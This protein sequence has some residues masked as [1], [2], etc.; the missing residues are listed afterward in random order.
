MLCVAADQPYDI[1]LCIARP[2]TQSM[3]SFFAF[4]VRGPTLYLQL[5]LFDSIAGLPDGNT[6]LQEGA[7]FVNALLWPIHLHA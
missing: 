3:I 4:N 1:V 6:V 7:E 2:L 5:A